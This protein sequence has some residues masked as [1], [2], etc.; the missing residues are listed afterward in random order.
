MLAGSGPGEAFGA[1]D[2]E[3][4]ALLFNGCAACHG[5]DGG[6]S[7]DGLVPRLAGQHASVVQK[8]L[9]E[10]RYDRRW[11]PRMQ[12]VVDQHS[13]SPESIIDISA[14]ISRLDRD[15]GIG[16]GDGALVRRGAADY[17]RACQSCH[18]R[19]ALGDAVRAVP[20]LAGQHY[21]YLRRQIYDAVDGRRPNFSPSHIRL[22]ARLNRDDIAGISD[23]LSRLGAS[24]AAAAPQQLKTTADRQ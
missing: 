3:R 19:A 16:T 12:A 2:L 11:D 1:P 5:P 8:Q 20:R 23:Y 4:G 17:S 7:P 15:V 24:P 9:M 22:L 10:Y 21:E 6:G 14:Y 13:L 18:G